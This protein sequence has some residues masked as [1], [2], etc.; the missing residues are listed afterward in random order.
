MGL[1]TAPPIRRS[2]G[3]TFWRR[4]RG[5]CIRESLLPCR[6]CR[7]AIHRRWK[8]KPIKYG[9][10]LGEKTWLSS[11]VFRDSHGYVYMCNYI[12]NYIYINI[13]I[14]GSIN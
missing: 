3:P 5:R 12:Y 6:R 10:S 4:A 2:A 8:D 13:Y 1:M 7:R 11:M 14:Y 9:G